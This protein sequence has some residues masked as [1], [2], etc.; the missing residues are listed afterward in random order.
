MIGFTASDIKDI[1]LYN[2]EFIGKEKPSENSINNAELY[3]GVPLSFGNQIND[4][5]KDKIG[6][7]SI[8]VLAVLL[9]ILMIVMAVMMISNLIKNHDNSTNTDNQLNTQ[10]QVNSAVSNN[11][12]NASNSNAEVSEVVFAWTDGLNT[13]NF[14]GLHDLYA[15]KVHY[16]GEYLSP[17]EIV[18]NQRKLLE[19]YQDFNQVIASEISTQ[20]ISNEEIRLYFVKRVLHNGKTK[21]YPSYLI[22]RFSGAGY[23]IVTESDLITDRNLSISKK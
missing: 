19:K 18:Y 9:S 11:S 8:K 5:K 1:P 21:D 2:S 20:R 17:D 6:F 15:E 22:V 4:K 16:Y 23:K 3:Y 10:E 13:R 12:S 7:S 14:E